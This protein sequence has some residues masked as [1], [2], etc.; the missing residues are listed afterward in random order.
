MSMFMDL[1]VVYRYTNINFTEKQKEDPGKLYDLLAGSGLLGEII[2]LIPQS[3]YKS[4]IMWLG[5]TANNI[6]EYRNSIYG[7]LDAIG[8][9]YS[10]LELDATKIQEQLGNEENLSLLRDVMEKL[11]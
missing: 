6:Y 11:G 5:K 9:D 2:M 4:I 1:E 10:N 3:E 7:I 8:T